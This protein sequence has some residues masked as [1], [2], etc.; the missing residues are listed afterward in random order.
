MDADLRRIY[1]L[2]LAE[3]WGDDFDADLAV[4]L[5]NSLADDTGTLTGA[6]AAGYT[7]PASP[8]ELATIIA[9]RALVGESIDFLLPLKPKTE[10]EPE[11][12]TVIER[13][14][15]EKHLEQTIIFRKEKS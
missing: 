2:T 10:P 7:R 4:L 3:V 14:R 8:L 15:A 6:E 5:V 12:V 9:A 1:H 13:R 11:K